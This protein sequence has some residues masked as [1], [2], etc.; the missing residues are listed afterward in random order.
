MFTQKAQIYQWAVRISESSHTKTRDNVKQWLYVWKMMMLL[1]FEQSAKRTLRSIASR[2][3][4]QTDQRN[5][6]EI[7]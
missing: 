7:D 3:S 6:R 1:M 5:T 4:K 2:F